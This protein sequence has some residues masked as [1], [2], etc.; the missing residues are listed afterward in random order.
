M[1]TGPVPLGQ[2]AAV[3][4]GDA[5]PRRRGGSRR[6]KLI[7][8]GS[9]LCLARRCPAEAVRLQD[10][11]TAP[12]MFEQLPP[13]LSQ[14]TQKSVGDRLC[15]VHVP[16]ALERWP[17]CGG[18][19][20]PSAGTCYRRGCGDGDDHRGRRRGR[21][22]S[23]V[24]VLRLDLEPEGVADVG[25]VRS[26][27]VV[28]ADDVRA[29]VP[30]LVAAPP[31]V[32]VVGRSAAPVALVTGEGL[33]VLRRSLDRRQA[34]FAGS[35]RTRCRSGAGEDA[36]ADYERERCC[37]SDERAEGTSNVFCS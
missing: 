10:V 37:H 12:A 13:V 9:S 35:G 19:R 31:E 29:V 20:R 14:R 26:R 1:L 30:A 24:R 8:P 7:R 2:P 6:S 18:C 27:S 34:V 17:S 32:V 25:R 21:G 16:V 4:G 5:L 3:G 11:R 15:T 28:R 22:R 23:A 36:E 33:A